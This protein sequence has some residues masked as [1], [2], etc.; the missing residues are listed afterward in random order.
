[1]TFKENNNNQ[2]SKVT[3]RLPEEKIKQL[4][5]FVELSDS[6]SRNAFIEEAIDFYGGYMMANKNRYLP[7]AVVSSLESV[8]K[9]SEDRIARLLFKN[10]VELAMMLNVVAANYEI[11]PDTMKKLRK[12]CVSEV[13]GTIGKI[14][15]EDIYKYQNSQQIYKYFC[16]NVCC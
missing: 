1:M 11:D 3:L 6:R 4:D 10:T 16:G 5:N 12:Q 8:V 13:K 7:I 14:N 9:L 15:F 2:R